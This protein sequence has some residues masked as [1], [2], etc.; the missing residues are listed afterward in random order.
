MQDLNFPTW[1]FTIG[2]PSFVG[3]F[4]VFVYLFCSILSFFVFINANDLFHWEKAKKQKA[5]WFSI[6]LV[7][8]F[9]SIN[10]QLDIQSYATAI[11]RYHALKHGWYEQRHGYQQLFI[12]IIGI[13]SASAVGLLALYF[14]DVIKDNFLAILGLGSLLAFITIRASS[15]HHVDAF[16]SSE[17]LNLKMNWIIELSAISLICFAAILILS[18]LFK[19]RSGIKTIFS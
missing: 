16:I 13:C 1:S 14:I 3:W 7:M 2:D 12:K 15:F 17:I 18:R 10:K 5:F 8:L 11:A 9:L 19:K 6:M 4:T